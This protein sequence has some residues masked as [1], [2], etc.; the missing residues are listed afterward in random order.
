[1]G[2]KCGRFHLDR[3]K[4]QSDGSRR[5]A[6]NCQGFELSESAWT[7]LGADLPVSL[8]TTKVS[9]SADGNRI[10]IAEHRTWDA[11]VGQI[12]VFDWSGS[13]WLQVGS[14]ISVQPAPGFL[15]PLELEV[16]MS[17][18]GNRFVVGA[19]RF[20]GASNGF[21]EPDPGKVEV[22]EWSGGDWVQMGSTILGEGGSNIYGEGPNDSIGRILATNFDGSRFAVGGYSGPFRVYDWTGSDWAQAGSDLPLSR[23][24]SV[25]MSS[26]GSRF[27]VGRG[28]PG[29]A[30]VYEW[31]G[32]DWAQLGPDTIGGGGPNSD[33]FGASVSMSSDGSRVAVGA[34]SGIDANGN[35]VGY[36]QLFDWSGSAWVQVGANMVGT[37]IPTDTRLRLGGSIDLNDDGSRV[38]VAAVDAHGSP[39]ESYIRTFDAFIDSDNDGLDDAAETNTGVYISQSDT[40]TDPDKLDTDGDGLD[41]GFEVYTSFSD[42]TAWSSYGPGLNDMDAYALNAGSF[43][44]SQEALPAGTPYSDHFDYNIPDT[45]RADVEYSLLVSED[46]QSWYRAAVKTAGGSWV[47]DIVD[48]ATPVYPGI[49]NVSVTAQGNGVTISDSY[50]ATRLFFKVNFSIP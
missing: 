32:S 35:V 40:G 15:E 16:E 19:H 18:D 42:P 10:A 33:I 50:S 48:D 43:G 34:T 17:K 37:Y 24:D 8:G 11:T 41:D 12:K 26:D 49:D 3:C 4:W 30:R 28:W 31:S 1:L 7:Q 38:V 14:T 5:L 21:G 44:S 27:I 2:S 20:S 46:L 22:Y 29:L 9:I 13:A 6:R 23:F 39:Y 47:K 25:A 36:A 45:S